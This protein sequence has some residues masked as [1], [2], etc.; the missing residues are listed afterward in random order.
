MKVG[1][2]ENKKILNDFIEEEKENLKKNLNKLN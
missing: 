1:E 2:Y